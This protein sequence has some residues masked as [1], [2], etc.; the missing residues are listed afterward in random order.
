[1]EHLVT[2]DDPNQQ[3]TF[4]P[5]PQQYQP[6]PQTG[7]PYGYVPQQEPPKKRKKWPWIVGGIALVM[8]LG[9]VGVFTLVIGGT[10]AAIKGA[11]DN[12]KGKNAVAG[13]V[14]RPA[15]DGKFQ[16]TVTGQSCGAKSVGGEY[17]QKAQGQFC[18]VDVQVKNVGTSAEIFNDSSQKGYDAKGVEYS[19]NSGAAVYANKD[20]ST[21]LEQINPGNTVRGKLVF[22]MPAGTKLASVVVHESLFTPGVKVPLS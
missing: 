22:D 1:M 15:K 19:V 17:G 10:G 14:G 12:Q 3:H 6:A 2:Y 13:Q 11:D 18:F 16:F 7:Q 21:F 20:Y 9:C 4:N 8:A 5:P